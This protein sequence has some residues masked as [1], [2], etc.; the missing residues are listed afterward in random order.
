MDD[1][2]QVAIFD[3]VPTLRSAAMELLSQQVV[4]DPIAHAMLRQVAEV[5]L[6][7]TVREEA[8]ALLHSPGFC[9]PSIWRKK[10]Q[11]IFHPGGISLRTGAPWHRRLRLG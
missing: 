11:A 3:P 5:A 1:V 4:H 9:G 2:T 10:A 7:E 6:D 8:Q